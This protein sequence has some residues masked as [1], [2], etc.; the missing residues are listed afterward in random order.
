MTINKLGLGWILAA[1]EG[2]RKA[3]YA[4]ILEVKTK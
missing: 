4:D 2:L 1:I 3:R